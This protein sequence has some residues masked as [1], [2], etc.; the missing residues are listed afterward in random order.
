LLRLIARENPA[1]GPTDSP[2]G[3]S[4]KT[5]DAAGASQA[6][7]SLVARFARQEQAAEEQFAAYDGVPSRSAALVDDIHAGGG[8]VPMSHSLREILRP[9]FHSTVEDVRIHADSAATRAVR[10]LGAEAFTVG[11]DVYVDPDQYRAAGPALIAHELTHVGQQMAAGTRSLQPRVRFT[12]TPAALAKVVTL[13][14]GSLDIRLRASLNSTGDLS[15]GSSGFY[16][17]PTLMQ[18]E[19]TTRIQRIIADA[20]LVTEGVTEGGVPLVGSWTLRQIDVDDMTAL[21]F[22]EQGWNAG[23]SLIHELTEQREQ[24]VAGETDFPT[25]HATATAAENAVI[26][27]VQESDTSNMA[28]VGGGRVSGTRTTVF[29]YPNGTRWRIIV[30]VVNSNITNVDR[31]QLP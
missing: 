27:A 8:G 11:R 16:G 17:P 19:F 22:N 18:S 30:T 7:E 13:I 23:A 14:N 21:G 12:G 25:A 2:P 10:G 31:V 3:G 6:F 1:N 15:I 9:S 28:P 20:G 26:G 5:N 24:Q 29:R 4:S